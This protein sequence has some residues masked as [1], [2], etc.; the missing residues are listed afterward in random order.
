MEVPTSQRLAQGRGAD[1]GSLP[2]GPRSTSC[3]TCRAAQGTAAMP[4]LAYIQ[5]GL[6]AP[7]PRVAPAGTWS[8][9]A[10]TLKPPAP[11]PQRHSCPWASGRS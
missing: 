4:R 10:V 5:P 7:S 2:S 3:C 6:W 9:R 8:L 1:A 11:P